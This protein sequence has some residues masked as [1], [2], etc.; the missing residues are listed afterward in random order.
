MSPET[1]NTG[2]ATSNYA[3]LTFFYGPRSCIGRDFAKAEFKCLLAALAGAM[4]WEL[5]NPDEVVR[6]AGV[7]TMKSANGMKLRMERVSG[8]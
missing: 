8:W 7:V 6:P 5:A 4:K 3:N 1:A 2:G